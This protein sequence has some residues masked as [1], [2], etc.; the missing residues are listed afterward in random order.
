MEKYNKLVRDRIPEII[1][2]SGGKCKFHIA[3]KSEVNELLGKKLLEEVNEFNENPCIEEIADIL[4]V[5]DVL[6]K[7]YRF[8]LNDIR[9]IK[10]EKKKERGSFLNGIVLDEATK[11]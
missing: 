3:K 9:K 8:S 7:N 11:K 10:S 5:V 1:K 4:E 6:C 2:K